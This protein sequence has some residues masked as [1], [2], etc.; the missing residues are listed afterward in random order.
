M[1]LS[2]SQSCSGKSKDLQFKT[3]HTITHMI[4]SKL[5]I[6]ASSKKRRELQ[7]TQVK[8]RNQRRIY[9]ESLLPDGICAKHQ[10]WRMFPF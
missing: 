1:C 2:P 6:K 10:L 5:N 9:K 3:N 7:K 8:N 4:L